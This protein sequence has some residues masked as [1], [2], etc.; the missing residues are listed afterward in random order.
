MDIWKYYDTTHHLHTYCNPVSEQGFDELIALLDL[1]PGDR[2]LD[3][4]C[5]MGELMIRTV[6][7]TGCSAVGVDLSPY[8]SER[9]RQRIA[10]RLPD[11]DIRLVT[12]R[13]EDHPVPEDA[14]F[15]LV[16]CIGA[17][18]IW[19][20]CEG[21]LRALVE[22]ARPGGLVIAGE[23]YWLQAPDPEYLRLEELTAEMFPASLADYSDFARSL[24]LEVLW[25]RGSSP[26]DW[27]R[28]EMTQ[29][30]AFDRW[31]REH[32]DHPDLP[33]FREKLRVNKDAYLRWGRDTLGFAVWLFR[34]PM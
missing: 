27:D 4:A 16:S 21:T 31:S 24:G 10:S 18:W 11:A 20:G 2:M 9:G 17:S 28:Y 1:G 34:T 8:A 22:R 23:P 19:D 25:M 30:L 15:D 14:R 6:E 32:P 29:T 12:G 7:R 13:A 5:G 33:A 26:E 3:I